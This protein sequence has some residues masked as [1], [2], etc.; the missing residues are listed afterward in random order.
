MEQTTIEKY[1]RKIFHYLRFGAE[2]YT[3]EFDITSAQGRLLEIIVNDTLNGVD[4]TRKHLEQVAN[5]KGSS[6]TSLLDGLQRKKFIIKNTSKNDRRALSIKVTKRG[7]AA[8]TKVQELFALQ[9]KQLLL[10]MTKEE[11]KIFFDLLERAC[12]NIQNMNLVEL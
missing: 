2:K 3:A 8:I 11:K 9:E 5:V 1:V 12:Q 10:G 4:V 6:I 7:Y